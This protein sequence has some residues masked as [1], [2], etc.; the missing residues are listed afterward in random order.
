[1]PEKN[2]RYDR[3]AKEIAKLVD[4]HPTTI[5]RATKQGQIPALKVGSRFKYNEEEV[6]LAL[7]NQKSPK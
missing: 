2:N 4:C 3:S 1:M 7:S 6:R 5:L